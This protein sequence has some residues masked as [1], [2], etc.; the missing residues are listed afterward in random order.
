M[1]H[2][3]PGT[4]TLAVLLWVT[5]CSAPP[6]QS[7]IVSVARA[8]GTSCD[9]S[10]PTLY[11]ESGA[12]DLSVAPLFQ[13]YYQVFSWENDL[14][15]ISVTV[16]TQITSET[17]NTFIATTIKDSYVMVGGTN[18]PN[19]LVS[20][21]ATIAPGGTPNDNSV[22]VFLLTNAA[23]QAICGN[24]T[25]LDNCPNFA[26]GPSTLLVTFQIAG[27]LVGGGAAQTNPIVFPLTLFKGGNVAADGTC[28]P[29][30]V[31]QTTGCGIPGRDIPYCVPP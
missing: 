10:D 6:D 22:G 15:N 28:K 29:P 20:I 18:P 21:S 26:G 14:Q 7:I 8:P 31:A 4:F 12:L 11:V 9:F 1:K 19:G 2:G 25:P 3:N 30:T 13:S 24:P 17:P 23:V 16:N 5:A 27:S